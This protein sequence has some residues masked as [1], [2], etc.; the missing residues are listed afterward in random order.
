[1]FDCC[2]INDEL[3]ILEV[4]LGTLYSTVE[5]FVIVE[6]TTTHTG[7]PKPLHV[8]ENLER[9]LPW[10]DKIILL[11]HQGHHVQDEVQAWGNENQQRDMCLQVLNDVKPSDGLLLISDVDEIIDPDKLLSAQKLA[12]GTNMPVSLPVHWCMYYFNYCIDNRP[13]YGPFLYD[14]SRAQEVHSRFG[15]TRYSPTAFRWHM[16]TPVYTHDFPMIENAGWHFSYMGGPQAI[17]KK[18]ESFAHV[19]KNTNDLKNLDYIIKCMIRG[20]DLYQS[21]ECSLTIK[22]HNFLPSYVRNNSQKFQNYIL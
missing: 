14:P 19:S 3:D 2:L 4:R 7:A 18:L 16:C 21:K 9:F 17:A 5:K 20:Q 11:T 12:L 15:Q 8:K 1:M 22:D 6:S 13:F 10:M